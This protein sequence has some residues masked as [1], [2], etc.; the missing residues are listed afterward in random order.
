[1]NFLISIVL[2]H[3]ISIVVGGLM[4]GILFG[5]YNLVEKKWIKA[6]VI[7]VILTFFDVVSN[8]VADLFFISFRKLIALLLIVFTYVLTV[9]LIRLFFSTNI[10][11]AMTIG[12]VG[13]VGL[14]IL[15]GLLVYVFTFL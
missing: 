9:Y 14:I 10:I 8:Y 5:F 15:D 2:P 11:R 3:T 4:W 13:F 7:S 12:T 1:M 6:F